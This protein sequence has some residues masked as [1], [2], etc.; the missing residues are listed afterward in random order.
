[1]NVLGVGWTPI[2]GKSA[3]IINLTCSS[4]LRPNIRVKIL[5]FDQNII[6]MGLLSTCTHF[7]KR[8]VGVTQVGGEI[9]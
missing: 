1:M 6:D 5:K 7:Q 2:Y 3:L 9:N 4:S 8:N